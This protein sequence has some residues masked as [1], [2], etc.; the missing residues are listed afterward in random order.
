M[1]KLNICIDI[2]GTITNAYYWIPFANKYFNKD[3]KEEDVTLYEMHEVFN[4]PK[5][6]YTKFYNKYIREIHEAAVL[7]EDVKPIVDKLSQEN[8]LYFVTARDKRVEDITINFL[9]DNKIPYNDLFLLGNHYKVDK[10]IELSC[11]VFIEDNYSNAIQLSESGF[12]VILIDTYY[13]R[14]KLNDKITRV[15]TWDEIYNIIMNK[16]LQKVS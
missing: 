13:N 9:K 15:K 7:R 5:E 12:D 11:D 10:A 6:K 14:K 3:I 8:N 2:D 1:G 16:Y 4:V